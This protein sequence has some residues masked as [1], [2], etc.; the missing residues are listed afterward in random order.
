MSDYEK[1]ETSPKG[2]E[3]SNRAAGEQDDMSKRNYIRWDAEGVEKVPP[4]EAE[5]IQA[6][7]DMI[8]ACQKAQWNS[9]RHCFSGLCASQ[10]MNDPGLIPPRD[11]RPYTRSSQGEVGRA[12][13]LTQTP[14]A[15][16][17]RTWRRISSGRSL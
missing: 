3:I 4:N 10:V 14:E 17:I 12:G 8:N 5:D 16:S 15:E 9:H 11:P 2:M 6:V 13:R 1:K 7:A